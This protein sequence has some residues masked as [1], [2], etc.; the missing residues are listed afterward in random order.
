[1]NITGRNKIHERCTHDLISRKEIVSALKAE[2]Y[3]IDELTFPSSYQNHFQISIKREI[4]V[5]LYLFKKVVVFFNILRDMGVFCS[6]YLFRDGN[7]DRTLRPV[8]YILFKSKLKDCVFWRNL[9]L[10]CRANLVKV[11]CMEAF[12]PYEFEYYQPLNIAMLHTIRSYPL[13]CELHIVFSVY[14]CWSSEITRDVLYSYLFSCAK[15]MKKEIQIFCF[16][17]LIKLYSVAKEQYRRK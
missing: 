2:Q 11:S 13:K 7:S 5:N 4:E 3:R 17:L 1:M 14:R 16:P 6:I 10:E 9:F 15:V 8:A 12:V